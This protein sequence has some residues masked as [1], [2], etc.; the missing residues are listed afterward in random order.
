MLKKLVRVLGNEGGFTLV[1]LMVV[2][3]IIGVIAGIAVPKVSGYREAAAARACEANRRAIETAIIAY[4]AHTGNTFSAGTGETKFA[5]LED[6]LDPVPTCP[7]R[8][9]Y[10]VSGGKVTCSESE[11]IDSNDG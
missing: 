5:D 10:T 3:V 1:E 9:E 11:H 4:E 8:G 7:G 2:L 6:Y